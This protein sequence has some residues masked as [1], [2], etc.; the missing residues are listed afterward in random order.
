M[1]PARNLYQSR[2]FTFLSYLLGQ[3][4]ACS[5]LARDPTQQ[6]LSSQTK[7][8]RSRDIGKLLHHTS[9]N[10][11]D[12]HR[13]HQRR[14]CGSPVEPASSIGQSGAGHARH[15]L[16]K[17]VGQ[18]LCIGSEEG[19]RTSY[20]ALLFI[21]SQFQADENRYAN[22]HVLRLHLPGDHIRH[23][24]LRRFQHHIHS[25]GDIHFYLCVGNIYRLRLAQG[26]TRGRSGVGAG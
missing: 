3:F 14:G 13:S 12:A 10:C 21:L 26:K 7:T 22:R 16:Q 24:Y 19:G 23:H 6:E 2:L 9:S 4:E 17:A 20:H 25:G 11:D 1:I 15:Q 8:A 5:R 18:G